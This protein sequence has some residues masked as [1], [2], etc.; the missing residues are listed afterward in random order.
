LLFGKRA[1]KKAENYNEIHEVFQERKNRDG[2]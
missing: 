1:E 2:E